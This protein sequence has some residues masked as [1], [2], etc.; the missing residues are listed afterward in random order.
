MTTNEK[1]VYSLMQRL[2]TLQN[3]KD[4]NL[5]KGEENYQKKLKEEKQKQDL[6]SKKRRREKLIKSLKKKKEQ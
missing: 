5:K 6:L 1:N 3:I 4:K 2:Q